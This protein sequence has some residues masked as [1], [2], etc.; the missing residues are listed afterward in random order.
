MMYVFYGWLLVFLVIEIILYSKD[1]KA[2][3]KFIA[4]LLENYP[5]RAKEEY[6]VSENTDRPGKKFYSL[7]DKK[8]E[9]I[10][11][12]EFFELKKKAN[13]AHQASNGWFWLGV[14]VSLGLIIWLMRG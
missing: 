2:A 14:I 3:K 11:E 1:I 10:E 6:D 7:L 8:D 4:Y 13:T 9:D 5:K 12:K